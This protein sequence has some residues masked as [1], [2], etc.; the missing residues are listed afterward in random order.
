MSELDSKVRTIFCNTLKV[1]E[2]VFNEDLA[3][4][5]IPQWDSIGHVNL[6]M[7]IEKDFSITFDV[8]DAIDIESIGDLLDMIEKYTSGA[9]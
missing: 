5:D 6:L 8:G 3:A 9:N 4:G 7:A 2:S 1:E